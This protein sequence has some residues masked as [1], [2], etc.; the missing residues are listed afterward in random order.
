MSQAAEALTR[1]R[2]MPD[3]K[4]GKGRMRRAIKRALHRER[5][6]LGQNIDE[7]CFYLSEEI[8]ASESTIEKWLVGSNTA[9][10]TL[11]GGNVWDLVAHFGPVFEA[12]VF[13]ELHAA[14][15]AE[16]RRL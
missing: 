8:S 9:G 11:G 1:A 5:A 2:L 4:T 12:E 16:A 10:V 14:Q 7:F 13:Q 15:T 6:K 3:Q